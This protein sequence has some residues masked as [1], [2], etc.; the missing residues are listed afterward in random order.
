MDVLVVSA[1]P[2]ADSFNHAITAAAERGLRRA[3]HHVTTLDLYAVGFSAVMTADEHR[4]YQAWK[5]G[6]AAPPLLDPMTREHARLVQASQMLV[7]VY[8][9]WWSQPPAILKGWLERVLVPGVAFTFDARGRVR[10]G[11][12]HVRRIVGIS[13]YGS[14]WAYVKL[15]NDGGRRIITRALRMSCGL[16]TPTTWLGLYSIDTAG[17]E[18]R[19]A[20]LGRVE[21]RLAHLGRR[22]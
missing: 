10:P 19:K 2:D 13:T 6:N 17:E 16:R 20:F 1:H 9:T 8:P 12:T 11:M 22:P 21:H 5:P 4:A 3:G 7:F 14:P 18:D 15:I